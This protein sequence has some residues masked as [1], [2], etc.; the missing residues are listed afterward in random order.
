MLKQYIEKLKKFLNKITISIVILIVAAGVS[1]YL[2]WKQQNS[3][4]QPEKALKPIEAMTEEEIINEIFTSQPEHPL[5]KKE[6]RWFLLAN[7]VAQETEEI[8]ISNCKP[9]PLVAKIK[10]GQS[11]KF[12]N[13]DS[14][15]HKISLVSLDVLDKNSELKLHEYI[16]SAGLE[17][18]IT[19]DIIPGFYVYICDDS[20]QPAGVLGLTS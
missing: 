5:G 8:F 3:K 6:P 9:N 17:T 14:I 11:V 18:I 16:L 20:I 13:T 19:P 1:G 4:Q 10:N 15:E 2:I 7:R 12:Q